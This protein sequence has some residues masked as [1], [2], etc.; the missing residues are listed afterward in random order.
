MPR[1]RKVPYVTLKKYNDRSDPALVIRDGQL[2]RG[3]GCHEHDADGAEKA[4]AC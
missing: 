3:T 2:T 4:L 1:P